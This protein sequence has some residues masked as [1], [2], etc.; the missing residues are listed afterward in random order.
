MSSL[1]IGVGSV[2]TAYAMMSVRRVQQAGGSDE[3]A[4]M[5]QMPSSLEGDDDEGTPATD[6]HSNVPQASGELPP[7]IDV[8]GLLSMMSEESGGDDVGDG[9]FVQMSLPEDV[10][11]LVDSDGDGSISSSELSILVDDHSVQLSTLMSQLDADGDGT[12]S[13]EELQAALSAPSDALAPEPQ[14]DDAFVRFVLGQYQSAAGLD[15]TTSSLLD[16]AA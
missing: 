9:E 6:E 8:E 14:R 13:V 7:E 4:S 15:T 10:N 12:V 5:A 2:Y 1:S 16:F 11:S 3:P